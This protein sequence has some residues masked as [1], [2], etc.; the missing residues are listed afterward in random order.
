[1]DMWDWKAGNWQGV[2]DSEERA[3]AHAE[4][5]LQH[6]MTARVVKV[7]S[8]YGH[9]DTLGSGWHGALNDQGEVDWQFSRE[10]WAT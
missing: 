8:R 5:H 6:G 7:N 9:S 10:M 1:M 2:T 3:L 4:S